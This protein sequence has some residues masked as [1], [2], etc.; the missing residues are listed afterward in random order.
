LK[1]VLL[2]FNEILEGRGEKIMKEVMN[3]KETVDVDAPNYAER[4][5]NLFSGVQEPLKKGREREELFKDKKGNEINIESKFGSGN[6]EQGEQAFN[7]ISQTVSNRNDFS[8]FK[9]KGEVRSY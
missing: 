8:F 4:L 2:E 9:Q 5:N 3:R 1:K 6:I 7:R